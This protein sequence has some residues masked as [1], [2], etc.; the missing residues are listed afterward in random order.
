M[1]VGDRIREGDL[2]VGNVAVLASRDAA[3]TREAAG[4]LLAEG[5][6]PA[7]VAVE[8]AVPAAA[9]VR[10]WRSEVGQLPE[11]T[12]VITADGTGRA[13][14]SVESV[15][16]ESV[17]SPADFTGMGMKITEAFGDWMEGHD[18]RLYLESLDVL[19]EYADTQTL[20]QFLHV[21]TNRV[22]A[23]GARARYVLDPA[24]VSDRD[25]AILK[26]LMDG[27]IERG[28]DAWTFRHA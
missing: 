2:Q 10:E 16:T 17:A 28:D 21:L 3:V 8:F 23:V 7:L 24:T 25:V 4:A 15:R 11:Q 1:R 14:T 20:Y 19:M 22:D 9:W 26:T 18:L 27:A 6:D 13:S 5:D 12:L